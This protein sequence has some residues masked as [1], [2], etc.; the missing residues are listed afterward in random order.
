MNRFGFVEWFRPGDRDRVE[1][2]MPLLEETGAAWLRTHLS[3][4]DYHTPDGRDWYDWLLPRLAE[5]AELVPCIHYTPPSL[6]RTG[7][8][9]GAP[10]VLKDLADFCDTVMTRYGGH[11][12]HVELWNEPNNLLDYDWR[13]DPG[14]ELFCEMIGMAAH[15]IG[16]RGWKPVLGGPCPF[17]PVWLDL[18]GQRGL[19]SRVQAVGFHGFPGTWDS[20]HG[21]WSGWDAH[22][23]EMREI[24]DRHNRDAEIWIT[25]T[26]YSTWRNEEM[27]QIRRFTEALDAPADRMFWYAL[28]DL[29]PEVAVQEGLW[30]DPRHYHLGALTAD[31]Q[32]KLLARML[33]EGG[34]PRLRSLTR[35]CA[36]SALKGARPVV[37]TGGAGFIGSNLADSFLCEGRDV[38]VLDN[39]SRAGVEEN[40]AWLGDRH[41]A[42]VHPAPVDLRNPQ[43]VNDA[44][45]DAP[46]VFHLAA[47]T[48]VTRSLAAPV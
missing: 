9:S 33:A 21:S 39:L 10:L 4:A 14:Y 8:S 36:P 1:E 30:F 16:E 29:Q 31:G 38:V 24:L 27:E 5:S 44:V 32:P 41:G 22:L 12:E 28:Q 35:L 40:L 26:G 34:V 2:V 42:L 25:E 46:A 6:S 15:W 47:Q 19:L 48:A 17:D 45:T 7:R 43:D 3:W 23:G 37:I 18:M 11:F 13:A 20:E